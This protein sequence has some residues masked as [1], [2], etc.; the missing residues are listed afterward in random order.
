MTTSMSA[1]SSTSTESHA[2]TRELSIQEAI[3]EGL[4][5]EMARDDCVFVMGEDVGLYGGH[6]QVT[7]GLY[8]RFGASRV[9]DTPISEGQ[10]A[11]TAV[12]AA[13]LG[14]RPIAEIQHIDFITLAL[15]G[16]VN[17]ATLPYGWGGQ[18]QVPLVIRTK[19]GSHTL[20]LQHAKSLEAWLV[21]IPGLKVVQPSTPADA[22][23]LI[24]AAVRDPNPVIFI[25]HKLTYR[26]RG[27]VPEGDITVP[28]GVADVKRSGRDVTVIAT[29]KMVP[30]ALAAAEFLATEG[31]SVEVIDPRTLVPLDIDTISESV[32]K[33]GRLVVT[34][35]AWTR[36]GFGAE[37]VAAVVERGVELHAAPLR[38]CGANVPPPFSPALQR[39]SIPNRE[40]LVEQIRRIADDSSTSRN[41]PTS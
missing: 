29:S 2:F 22:K 28:I 16:I 25:E 36:G 3:N 12:G 39:I 24:K 38:I 31:I 6:Q 11:M 30:E 23:G 15:D 34:H 21:H 10:I 41:A 18:V 35:E 4:Q 32:A 27:P 14:M 7:E 20:G 8:E 37:V 9:I 19:D 1:R 33:T 17:H 40:R 13:M 26:S 5:E